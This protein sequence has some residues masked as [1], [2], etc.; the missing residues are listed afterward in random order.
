MAAVKL[1]NR[2]ECSAPDSPRIIKNQK[3]QFVDVPQ[4]MTQIGRQPRKSV[5]SNFYEP[6]VSG[7]LYIEYLI[8]L[9]A[10]I[11]YSFLIFK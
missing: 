6:I 4:I 9:I 11:A 2:K 1:K 8:F 3:L 7:N 5:S 10:I